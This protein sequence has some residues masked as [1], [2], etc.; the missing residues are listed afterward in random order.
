MGELE[1]LLVLYSNVKIAY[2]LSICMRGGKGH[3]QKSKKI[4][5]K[6]ERI[7]L[8]LIGNHKPK[9]HLSIKKI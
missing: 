5:H 6:Y 8:N 7:Y 4:L 1:F 2:S 3:R 9:I